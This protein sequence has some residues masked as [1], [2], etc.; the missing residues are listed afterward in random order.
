LE[1]WDLPAG[2]LCPPIPGRSDYL[3]YIADLLSAGNASD[4]PRG[5]QVNVLDIGVGANCV[6]PIVGVG[7]YGWKFVGTEVDATALAWAQQLVIKNSNL[8]ALID[9]RLQT[10]PRQCFQGVI[11]PGESFHVSICNPP[12]HTSAEAAAAGTQRKQRNLTGRKNL[13]TKLNFGG[14]H[15]ELWCPG[16]E[17]LFVE[18]MIAQSAK[19][20]MLCR[21]F[22]SLISKKEHLPQ[23]QKALQKSAV[24]QVRVLDMAQGQKRSRILAWSFSQ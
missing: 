9:L 17:L 5:P 8:R 1:Y 2:Y 15:S 19:V 4:V 21:W 11:L 3:H 23:L 10:T 14:T 18:R 22:T 12:F 24:K 7:E 20:P 16:G 13:K 6:Y